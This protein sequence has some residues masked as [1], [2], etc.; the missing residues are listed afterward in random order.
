MAFFTN[1]QKDFQQRGEDIKSSVQSGADALNDPNLNPLQKGL[2]LA[3]T[4][5]QTA[6]SVAGGAL[7]IMKEGVGSFAK[8][9]A[10]AVVNSPVGQAVT[11]NKY[12]Q[13]GAEAVGGVLD[14][15]G[16][17][18]VDLKK[19]YPESVKTAEAV[20]N[21]GLLMA[22]DAAFKKAGSP[23]EATK[24]PYSYEQAQKQIDNHLK[25]ADQ[26]LSDPDMAGKV[27]MNDLLSRT[28]TN[29]VD[30]L[31]Q[32]GAGDVAKEI[33]KLDLAAYKDINA[34]KA[35]VKT[36]F[37]N[38]AVDQLVAHP[39]T[40][41]LYRGEGAGNAGGQHFTPDASWAKN[42]GNTSVQGKLPAGSKIFKIDEAS[43]QQAM[44]QG[45]SNDHDFY[46]FLFNKGY[47][48]VLGSDQRN[49][50]A[51][52]I[53]VNPKMLQNFK[54]QTPPAVAPAAVAVPPQRPVDP[55]VGLDVDYITRT[56]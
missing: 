34:F 15:A 53:I 29:I 35:D 1:L 47:D 8:P 55:T 39:E 4:G 10:N 56:Q 20:G 54:V 48:A 31:K 9:I 24:K 51:L 25:T 3:G 14:K 49:P 40:I 42:F 37:V 46:N 50:F 23:A 18:Y 6:G 26:I 21:I 33:N 2:R 38:K 52:D 22:S 36:L 16:E 17:K 41:S 5:I 30:D 19:K 45:I 28:K 12:V 13:K 11:D 43:M 7:D 27:P 44:Q 32:A